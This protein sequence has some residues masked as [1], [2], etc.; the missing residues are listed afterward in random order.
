MVRD[1]LFGD[2]LLMQSRRVPW[3]RT[4]CCFCCFCPALVLRHLL[5]D[6][7]LFGEIREVL[8]TSLPSHRLWLLLLLRG[9][10]HSFVGV[11]GRCVWRVVVLVGRP[12][13]ACV[14]LV[15]GG[16]TGVASSECTKLSFRR[17]SSTSMITIRCWCFIVFVT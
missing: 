9:R 1:G 11:L 8:S 13:S 3:W 15:L 14:V 2:K 7:T 12:L 4:P 16:R 10:E 6:R 5:R 17:H